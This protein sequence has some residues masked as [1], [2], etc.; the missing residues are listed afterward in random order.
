[1]IRL[2]SFTDWSPVKTQDDMRE[3]F[4]VDPAALAFAL[5]PQE[6]GALNV[7]IAVIESVCDKLLDSQKASELMLGQR[8][9]PGYEPASLSAGS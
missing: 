1:M 7:K 9:I 2:L 5:L 4:P 3:T 6:T 8:G